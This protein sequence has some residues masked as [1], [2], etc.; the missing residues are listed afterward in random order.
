MLKT[1]TNLKHF[2]LLQLFACPKFMLIE[3]ICKGSFASVGNLDAL[4]WQRFTLHSL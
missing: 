3:G 4:V 2:A 1:L